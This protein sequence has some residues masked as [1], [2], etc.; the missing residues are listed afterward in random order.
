MAENNTYTQIFIHAVFAPK[1]RQA[2]ISKNWSEALHK[3][4]T[5]ILKTH[6]HKMIAI[7]SMPDHLHMFFGLHQTQSISDCIEMVKKN[8]SK[9][10]NANKLTPVHFNWQDGFGAFSYEKEK[11]SIIANYIE[12]QEEHHKKITW[13]E[14][15]I[16]ELKEFHVDYDERYIFK[17]SI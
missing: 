3:Y 9:W 6:K 5:G 15:F 16:K 13:R 7:N 11:I 17:D 10:I 8:S 12:N 2:L 1:F 4:I 14:E